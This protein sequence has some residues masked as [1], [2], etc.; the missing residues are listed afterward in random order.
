MSTQSAPG[1]S[2]R[3]LQL[4][5]TRLR[6]RLTGKGPA[7]VLL[8]GWALDLEYWNPLV[9]LLES[10]FTLLRFDRRGFGL[11]TGS[12]DIHRN[13]ED[14]AALLDAAGIERALLLGMSQGARLAIHFALRFPARTR[15]LLLDGAPLLEAE[16]ELPLDQY[17]RRLEAAGPAAMQ[18]EILQHPLMQLAT[19]DPAAHQLLAAIVARYRGSDLQQQVK[20]GRAPDLTAITMPT[21]ILNGSLDSAARCE[22]GRTLQA[23]IPGA[24]HRELAGAGHLAAL[25]DPAGYARVVSAFCLALPP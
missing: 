8:H 23:A 4:A 13:V 19:S 18:T 7:I 12:P 5:G 15:G 9:A 2:D 25:D 3:F 22:T 16:S 1:H 6:W 20:R 24:Q 10:R 11:S 17:R 21:L 14:L